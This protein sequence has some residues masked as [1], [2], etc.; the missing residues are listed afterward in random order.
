MNIEEKKAADSLKPE[1]ER[2][3]LSKVT[4]EVQENFD[5]ATT[6]DGPLAQLNESISEN[7]SKASQAGRDFTARVSERA[8]ELSDKTKGSAE[9]DASKV[10]SSDYED[11]RGNELLKGQ[12]GSEDEK[13]TLK[14]DVDEAQAVPSKKQDESDIGPDE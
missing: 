10:V 11:E 8:A 12:I 1:S 3:P 4:Q 6:G 7:F 9:G 14:F 2:N 13:T 5:K